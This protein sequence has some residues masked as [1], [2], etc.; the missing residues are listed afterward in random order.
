MTT[1]ITP[2]T[3]GDRPSGDVPVA[4]PCR[5]C[6]RVPDG[7]D[8]RTGDGKLCG[9]CLSIWT[10]GP[11]GKQAVRAAVKA[12]VTALAIGRKR[13]DSGSR[14]SASQ[15]QRTAWRARIRSR[16]ADLDRASPARVSQVVRDLWDDE[17]RALIL[18]AES[19]HYADE[20]ALTTRER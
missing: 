20:F 18:M 3:S 1:T 10:S 15:A 12:R 9:G 17:D 14:K 19:N 11:G 2:T 6:G 4:P 5:A 16:L 7:A 8:V 13:A